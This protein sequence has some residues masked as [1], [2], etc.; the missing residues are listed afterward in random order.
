VDGLGEGD[1]GRLEGE[2]LAHGM[3]T[4]RQVSPPPLHARAGAIGGGSA[5]RCRGWSTVRM[6]SAWVRAAF[7]RS[8]P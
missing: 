4:L 8:A 6:T 5:A 3:A 7:I 2:R 1:V